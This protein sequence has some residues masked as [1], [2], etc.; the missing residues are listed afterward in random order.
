[1]FLAPQLSKPR[2]VGGGVP[3]GV[4]NIPVSKIILNEPG[5]R[6]LIGERDAACVAQRVRM[7]EKVQGRGGAVFPQ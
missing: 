7:G 4:L 1:M 3:D 6:A 2:R 5:V